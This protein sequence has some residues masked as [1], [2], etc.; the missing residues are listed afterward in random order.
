M[1][2]K[3]K[4][5]KD[6]LLCKFLEST[7]PKENEDLLTNNIYSSVDNEDENSIHLHRN[8]SDEYETDTKSSNGNRRQRLYREQRNQ[9]RR[10]TA[11]YANGDAIN[12]LTEPQ[13]AT[14]NVYHSETDDLTLRKHAI[15]IKPTDK[16]SQRVPCK[17]LCACKPDKGTNLFNNQT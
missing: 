12:A 4:P 13:Q 10:C 7:E 3:F 11:K 15:S 5:E 8:D 2:A 17:R 6:N 9:R 14:Q 16:Q 1:A